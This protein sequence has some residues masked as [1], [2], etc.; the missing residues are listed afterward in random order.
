MLLVLFNSAISN[1]VLFR[2]N[3]VL[4]RDIANMFSV[5]LIP[6]IVGVAF[7]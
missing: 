1:M 3:F 7:N 5:R 2:N 4:S 6:V